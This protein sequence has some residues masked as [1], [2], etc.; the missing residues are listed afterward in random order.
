LI[1]EVQYMMHG[2]HHDFPLDPGRLVAPPILSWPI[3]TVLVALYWPIFGSAAPALFAGTVAGYLG[4]DWM[5][6][7]THHANPKNPLGR[8]M[9]QFHVEHHFGIAHSQFGLSSPL[10]DLAF[11]T[12]W[13]TGALKSLKRRS[14]QQ[15]A[16]RDSDA[17][18]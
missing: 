16:P 14:G 13:T 12:F 9:R 18:T 4:Y 2:Y 7:Y 3:A 15:R 5:H 8:F 10:W 17:V 11:G 1:K 6:Y